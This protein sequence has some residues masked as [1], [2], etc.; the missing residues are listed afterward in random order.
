MNLEYDN[1]HFIIASWAYSQQDM[2][3]NLQV[4]DRVKAIQEELVGFLVEQ[5]LDPKG[6]FYYPADFDFGSR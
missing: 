1:N 4:K 3:D 2:R 5:V 6:E